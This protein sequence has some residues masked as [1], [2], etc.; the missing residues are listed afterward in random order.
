MRVV[1]TLALLWAGLV[2]FSCGDSSRQ[3]GG[4][5]FVYTDFNPGTTGGF[6]TSD[7]GTLTV[8]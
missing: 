6:S 4:F 7:L 1:R 5:T 8:E 3:D 2:L